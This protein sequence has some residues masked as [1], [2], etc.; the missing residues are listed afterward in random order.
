[1]G[2]IRNR[3]GFKPQK[4]LKAK[5]DDKTGNDVAKADDQANNGAQVCVNGATADGGRTL[6]MK[7]TGALSKG[8][9]GTVPAK[10]SSKASSAGG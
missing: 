7:T 8:N 2:P 6:A 5:A 1:M 9:A 3:I 4:V 10:S